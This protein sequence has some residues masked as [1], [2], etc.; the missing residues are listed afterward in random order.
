MRLASGLTIKKLRCSHFEENLINLLK[1]CHFFN[2]WTQITSSLLVST[3]HPSIHHIKHT[4]PSV[5]RRRRR[6]LPQASP[7]PSAASPAQ[8]PPSPSSSQPPW[9]PTM[10]E[11]P[12]LPATIPPLPRAQATA[13]TRASDV[14]ARVALRASLPRCCEGCSAQRRSAER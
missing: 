7:R 10:T 6:A 14:V 13:E 11:P 4:K 1:N 8:D 2:I 9:P 3:F 12:D 5:T